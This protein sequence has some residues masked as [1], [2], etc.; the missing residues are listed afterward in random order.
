MVMVAIDDCWSMRRIKLST[1]FNYAFMAL[2]N[3]YDDTKA[4][5]IILI[6]DIH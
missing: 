6:N 2:L 3:E 4:D 5:I 1:C